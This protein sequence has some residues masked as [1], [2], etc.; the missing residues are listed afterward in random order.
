MG[1]TGPF[2]VNEK[3][4]V[5]HTDKFY[6]AKVLKAQQREDGLWYYLL[7]YTGWNKKW[8]EWVEE[9]GL[10][11][12]PTASAAAG[13]AAPPAAPPPCV[14]S[15]APG[16]TAP[17]P[18]AAAAAAAAAGV[19]G[20]ASKKQYQKS[21]SASAIPQKRKAGEAA[22]AAAAVPSAPDAPHQK[23]DI[24]LPAMLLQQLLQQ[25]D[26][27]HDDN[28]L[29]PLPRKPNVTQVR[30]PVAAAPMS[31]SVAAGSAGALG[32]GQLAAAQAAPVVA[33]AAPVTAA[34]TGTL[35]AGS[36]SSSRPSTCR[37]IL[38]LL[39][40]LLLP[41]LSTAA[42]AAAA[43]VFTAMSPQVYFDKALYQ[44]LL[45][46]AERQQAD[47]VLAAG[48]APSGVY[49]AEHL[50]R[51]FVKLPELLPHTGVP[52]EQLQLLVA[53]LDDVMAFMQT[54]T[55]LFEPVAS[56]VAAA[57]FA[58]SAAA[59]AAAGSAAAAAA[60]GKVAAAATVNGSGGAADTDAAAAAAA[61]GNVAGGKQ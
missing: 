14:S 37:Q 47:Q 60:A 9:T 18:A 19:A 1:D 33:A 52:E 16:P 26:A 57:G 25:Y 38:V 34:A 39:L 40:L 23:F 10:R 12:A 13:I 4:L 43:A 8:D 2:A 24:Q 48:A 32:P 5:P 56:Y 35:P 49:G 59:A 30:C 54:R 44:C 61:V 7:H 6:E 45:F 22:A 42:A 28:K 55:N 46:K 36:S 21:G 3:V 58:A 17:A 27:I 31:A 29:V 11:R 50:L 41:L 53:R 20:A 15:A 51:L